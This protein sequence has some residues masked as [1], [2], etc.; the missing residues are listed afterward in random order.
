MMYDII[1]K[2]SSNLNF[3]LKDPRV[4]QAFD[5]LLK[6][7]PTNRPEPE[8]GAEAEAEPSAS[9]AMALEAGER[10]SY[11]KVSSRSQLL[12]LPSTLKSLTIIGCHHLES[13]QHVPIKKCNCV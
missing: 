1:Q 7:S 13:L 10:I 3:Y 9:G 6:G 5:V 8:G 12:E 4:M 11:L 2:D